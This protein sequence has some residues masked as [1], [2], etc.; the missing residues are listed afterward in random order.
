MKIL[1]G[2][3]DKHKTDYRAKVAEEVEQLRRKADLLREMLLGVAEGETIGQGDVF[4]DLA[5][6]IRGSQPKLQKLIEDET[7]DTEAVSKF[8]ELSELITA[9]L[10]RYD[11]LRKGD[12]ERASN[13]TV[14]PLYIPSPNSNACETNR[15][16]RSNPITTTKKTTNGGGVLPTSLIDLDGELGESTAA[17]SSKDTNST[18]NLLDDLAGL[19]FQSNSMSFGRGG[20]IAL[21]QD[22]S[23]SS[24]HPLSIT[25]PLTLH[26]KTCS[27]QVP[28][29]HQDAPPHQPFLSLLPRNHQH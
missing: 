7:D 25:I 15:G 20:S 24:K 21:G 17:A 6:S 8:I 23:S 16:H 18:G 4:E 14:K 10:Q 2:Y 12:Y 27:R 1:S 22:T 3:D 19:S 13:V 9:D 5:I 26:C 28:Q 11:M 29:I